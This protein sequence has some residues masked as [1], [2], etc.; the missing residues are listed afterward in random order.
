LAPGI[1][2]LRA[3]TEAVQSRVTFIAGS[4]D[5]MFRRDYASLQLDEGQRARWSEL[6]APV[7]LYEF[8]QRQSLATDS[9]E[10]DVHALLE[11]LQAAGLDSALVVDL[12]RSD[13]GIPVVKVLVPGLGET[14]EESRRVR[15][16]PRRRAA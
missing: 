8:A 11:R 12:T 10:G 4:R 13:I 5:D 14:G 16:A 1:A 15:R 9:F 7:G 6:N 3:L 2:L